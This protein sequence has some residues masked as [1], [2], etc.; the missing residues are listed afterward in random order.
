MTIDATNLKLIP[1]NQQILQEAIKG[2][3]HLSQIL[4]CKVTENWSEFGADI[5]LYVLNIISKNPTDA[6]WWTYF[7]IHKKD[8]QLI[9]S[10]GYKG[11]PSADGSVEIGYEIAPEYRNKGFATE[12]AKALIQHAFTQNQVNIIYAH[13]LPEENASTKVLLKCQF[14]MVKEIIDPDEG[15][16]W[17]WQLL[18][19]NLK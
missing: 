7:P 18:R 15:K 4:K 5:F 14:K 3:D 9:G 10:G 17:K 6:T 16:I 2:N 19:N 8:N 1:C 12:M 13:T 11:K